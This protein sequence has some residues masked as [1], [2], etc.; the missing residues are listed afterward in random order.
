MILNTLYL[1]I[2]KHMNIKNDIEMYTLVIYILCLYLCEI[3]VCIKYEISYK[4]Q[5]YQFN[6]LCGL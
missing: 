4:L 1:C 5:K 2:S 6:H 3:Y